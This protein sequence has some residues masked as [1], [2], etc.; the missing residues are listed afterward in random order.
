MARAVVPLAVA[1]A[2]V[3][4]LPACAPD[5]EKERLKATTRATYDKATGR[6]KELTFDANKNGVV[7][8]WTH[9][10][11]PRIVDTEVDQDEDGKIDRWEYYGE[12]G[13]LEKVAL[14]RAKTGVP[15][16]WLYP[17]PD[18]QV[19][20]AEVS[21]K[22]DGTVDRWEWYER[23][24][25][26]RAE[27]DT[28]RDGRVDKWETYEAGRVVTAVFDEDRDGR[29]DRRLSYGPDGSLVSIETDP[30]PAGGFRRKVEVR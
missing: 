15:D 27:E 20:R 23:G 30:D 11:G 19:A 8:T 10:D 7:D 28:D 24:A 14:S 26:V 17:G 16:V 21:V 9:M 3:F 12:G 1:L 5:P 18:G 6:L 22:Q 4:S 25:L 2:C 13:R 29:P